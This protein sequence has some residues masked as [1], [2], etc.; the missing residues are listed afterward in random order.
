[1]NL[2]KITIKYLLVVL[3]VLSPSLA[4]AEMRSNSYIL[5][6][7]VNH[8]FNGPII[9][10]VSHSVSGV[11]VT[12]AF[13]TNV[14]ADAFVIYNTDPA[15]IDSMEQ[16]TSI[17]SGTSHNIALKGL[18]ADTTYYYRVR[19]ERVNGGVSTDITSRSFVTGHGLE[20]ETV[21]PVSGGGTLIIDKTDK[22]A[23][24]ISNVQIN[25]VDEASLSMSWDTNEEATSFGEYGETQQYGNTSGLWDKVIKHVVILKNLQPELI[26]HLRPV[27]SDGWG[28]VAYGEDQIFNTVAGKKVEGEFIASTSEENKAMEINQSVLAEAAKRMMSFVQRLFPQA[29]LNDKSTLGEITTIEELS[30]FIPAPIL[31]GEPRIEAG[32]DR[33]T[34]FW[35]TDIDASSQIAISPDADYKNRKGELYIQ[36]VGDAQNLSQNHSVQIFGLQADTAYHYQ[37]RSKA[38]FGP[39]AFSRD[40]TFRTIDDGVKIVSFLTQIKNDQAAS[41]KWVTNKEANSAIQYAPY[42]D[43]LVALDEVKIIKNDEYNIIHEID[44][45]DFQAGVFYDVEIISVDKKGNTVKE[46]LDRFSTQEND[47]PPEISNIKTNSTVFIDRNNKTQTVISWLTNEPT[48]AQI[49]YQEGVHGAGGE[50][51][52][53]TDVNNNFTKEHIFVITKFKPGTVYSFQIRA[54]DSGGNEVLSKINTFMTAKNKESIIQVIIKILEDTFGWVKKLM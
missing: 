42:H 9:S 54:I 22:I 12:V 49:F 2:I 7:N 36:V 50:L 41:I 47:L 10:G 51:S 21:V 4:S 6:E 26:Y 25:I 44:V 30:R 1:M 8:S 32:S 20:A 34:I 35:I 45:N 33:A 14:I 31:S 39:M 40:F 19:S 3:M 29:T 43:N 18:L 13:V 11:D 46:K 17:K 37:L 52:E 15:F 53:S 23:P 16:G 24:I 28:N 27:S 48:S 5:N 38:S